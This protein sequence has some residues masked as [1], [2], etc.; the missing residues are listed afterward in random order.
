MRR[1]IPELERSTNEFL[2]LLTDDE[3]SI[4][5]KTGT[6]SGRETLEVEVLD[7]VFVRPYETYS[8]GQS[9]RIAFAIRLALSLLLSK[10]A[11]V[12]LRFLVV[13]ESFGSNDAEGRQLIVGCIKKVQP[14]FD[15]ILV[16]THIEDIKESFT[17]RFEVT[18]TPQGSEIA[19]I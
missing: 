10:T 7:R 4:Q 14:Y 8:G 5:F 19:Q 16:I 2:G 3:L 12:Q 6:E 17:T 15:T 18:R 11:G 9:F 1:I 13:D